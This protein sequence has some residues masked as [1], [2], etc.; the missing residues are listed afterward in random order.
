MFKGITIT[1]WITIGLAVIAAAKAFA[2]WR[3][4]KLPPWAQTWAKKIGVKRIEGWIAQ[5]DRLGKMA[6][7]ERRAWVLEQLQAWALKEIGIPVPASV[8]NLLVEQVY[9]LWKRKK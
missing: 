5:A 9:Q 2:E 1:E 3:K 4:I 6:P 8:G 7:A